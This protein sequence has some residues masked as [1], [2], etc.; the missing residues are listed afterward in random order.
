M[1][2]VTAAGLGVGDGVGEWVGDGVGDA[3]RVGVGFGIGE[4]FGVAE[5]RIDGSSVSVGCAADG[6]GEAAAAGWLLSL[7]DKMTPAR[8]PKTSAALTTPTTSSG[9]T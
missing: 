3:V 5:A 4:G 8:I 6:L 9:G 1:V 2:S 7:R